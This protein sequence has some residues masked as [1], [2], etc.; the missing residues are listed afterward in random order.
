VIAI[1]LAGLLYFALIIKTHAVT[2][3]Q[4]QQIPKGDAVLKFAKKLRLL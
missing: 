1:P 4:L 2:A 3:A